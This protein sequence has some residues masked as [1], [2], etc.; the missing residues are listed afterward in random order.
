MADLASPTE[1]EQLSAVEERAWRA[2]VKAH[3]CLVK[4]LDAQLEAAHGLPLTSYEVLVRLSKSEGGKLRMHDIASSVLLSRSGLTRLID[5]LER[6]GLVNRCSCENDARGAYAVITDTGR[7]RVAE[8][9]A[10]NL[11]GVRSLFVAHYSEA[12]LELLGPLLE[13]LLPSDGCCS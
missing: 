8:A 7:E 4:R 5:R 13:R 6:D 12:E 9:R 11:D 3:A 1:L 10:T 2:L